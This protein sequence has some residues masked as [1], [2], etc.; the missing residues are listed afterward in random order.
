MVKVLLL[1]LNQ[2][3]GVLQSLTQF[4]HAMMGCSALAPASRISHRCADL[5]LDV[6]DAGS[7]PRL[8]EDSRVYDASI[9]YS[10]LPDEWTRS[11]EAGLSEGP[12][13]D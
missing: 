7:V 3:M 8:V 4:A 10:C 13:L 12:A 6:P 1:F 2:A 5:P 11:W 9:P